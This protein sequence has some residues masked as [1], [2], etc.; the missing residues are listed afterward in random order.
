MNDSD[1]HAS[2]SMRERLHRNRP[3][4]EDHDACS[5]DMMPLHGVLKDVDRGQHGHSP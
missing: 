5:G 1:D 2:L 4:V 3:E